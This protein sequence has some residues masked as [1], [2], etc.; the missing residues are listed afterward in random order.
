MLSS[1]VYIIWTWD[2]DMAPSNSGSA[3]DHSGAVVPRLNSFD[4]LKPHFYTVKL[5]FKRV[6][7][8][9]HISAEKHRLW[10]LVRSASPMRFYQVPTIYVLSRNMKTTRMFH[11]KI[12]NFLLVKFWIYLNRRVF[13]MVLNGSLWRLAVSLFLMFTPCNVLLLCLVCPV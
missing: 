5:E 8:N 12:F 13:V 6:Y 10:V 7:I 2:G 11:L 4:P 3:T 9:F 1:A